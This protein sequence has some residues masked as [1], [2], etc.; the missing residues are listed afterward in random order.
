MISEAGKVETSPK[1]SFSLPYGAAAMTRKLAEVE[2]QDQ[3]AK[4]KLEDE[5]KANFRQAYKDL[6]IPQSL[7]TK[8]DRN[9]GF[10]LYLSGGGFRGWGYLLMSQHKV[11]P[12]PIPIINGFQVN[13]SDFQNIAQIE[14]VAAEQEIFRV[15][16]RRATQVPAVAFLVNVLV[17]ALPDIREIR[18][19]QGGV[20]EGF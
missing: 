7:L 20:R 13:K 17:D 19:C 16:K 1:G 2:Q 14:T 3:A 9:G 12:Y 8:A 15:S 5:M 11:S 18:F 6:E 10:T 4:I